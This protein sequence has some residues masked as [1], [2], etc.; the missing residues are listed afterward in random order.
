GAER[1]LGF[2]AREA[3]GRHLSIFAREGG[4]QD[5]MDA[6]AKLKHGARAVELEV[7]ALARDGRKLLLSITLSAISDKR[8]RPAAATI[9]ARDITEHRRAEMELRKSEEWYRALVEES[10]D[11]IVVLERDG[12]I[13]SVNSSLRRLLGYR[14]GEVA[15]NN[16]LQWIHSDDLGTL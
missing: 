13:R 15:G 8:G 9:V 12:K 1:S 6:L 3:A 7:T 5:L 14:L 16:P 11:L 10:A 2:V 4:D